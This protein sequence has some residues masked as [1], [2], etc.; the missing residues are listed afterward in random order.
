M[1]LN[2]ISAFIKK[3]SS[4]NSFDISTEEGRSKERYRRIGIS[5]ILSIANKSVSVVTTLVSVPLTIN[6]L[7]T[8]RYGLWMTISSAMAMLSFAD[9][10]L[11]NGLLTVIAELNGKDDHRSIQTYVSSTFFIL[12]GVAIL[13]L[14]SFFVSYPFIPWSNLF[15]V[16]SNLAVQ[17]AN[18]AV[19]ILV[20]N[21]ALN[22]P[23]GV[24]QRIQ[25]GYQEDYKNQ[26]WISLGSLLGL[27]GILICI[28]F[29]AGLPWLILALSGSTTLAIFINGLN[30]FSFQKKWLFPS[31]KFFDWSAGKRIMKIGAIFMILQI[32]NFVGLASDNLIIAN[33]LGASSVATYVVTQKLFFTAFISQFFITPL[34]AAFGEAMARSDYVWAKKTLNRVLILSFGVGLSTA[35]ILFFCGKPVIAAWTNESLVPSTSLLLGFCCWLTMWGYV[36]TMSTFLNSGLLLKKQIVFFGLATCTSLFLKIILVGQW[37]EAG[38]IWATVIGYGIFYIIPAG[39]LAYKSI[40]VSMEI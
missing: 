30:L 27:G 18:P 33:S 22:M 11:G 15:N 28:Y 37:R 12:S 3:A 10:G 2:R 35:I 14:G 16:K 34:W 6:Y 5:T 13:I 20:I 7:G 24:V 21:L 23:L 32:L 38:V 26:V 1:K 4:S 19:A 9:L 8:E 29:N 17:E 31:L 36:G 25:S 40:S 39:R